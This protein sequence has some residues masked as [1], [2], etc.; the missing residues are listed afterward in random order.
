MSVERKVPRKGK[1]D[2]KSNQFTELPKLVEPVFGAAAARMTKQAIAAEAFSIISTELMP[3]CTLIGIGAENN[4]ANNTSQTLEKSK[5]S[6]ATE[7]RS[8]G[9]T[10]ITVQAHDANGLNQTPTH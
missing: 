10:T 2:K 7:S 3:I 9:N 6:I 5:S 4:I 1:Q 8:T